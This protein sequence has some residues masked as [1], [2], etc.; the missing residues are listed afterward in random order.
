M[1]ITSPKHL[2]ASKGGGNWGR[3]EG[4]GGGAGAGGSGPRKSGESTSEE[5]IVMSSASYPGM[6]WI[7]SGW[8]G[9]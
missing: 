5:K 9:E 1:G 2:S 7:P 3:N 8:E 4:S 6:E